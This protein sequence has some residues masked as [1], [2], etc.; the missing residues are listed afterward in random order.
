MLSRVQREGER[1]RA[2]ASY[3]ASEPERAREMNIIYKHWTSYVRGKRFNRLG[4]ELLLH[5]NTVAISLWFRQA[6]IV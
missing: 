1:M 2:R 4:N 5:K 6:A 3:L